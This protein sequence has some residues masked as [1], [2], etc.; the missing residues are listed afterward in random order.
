M[1]PEQSSRA[2]VLAQIS[3]LLKTPDGEVLMKEM[4]LSWDTVTLIAD[5]PER[6]AYAVGQRDAYKHLEWLRDRIDE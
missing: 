6:T 4:A 3:Q 5:T 1:P 2:K